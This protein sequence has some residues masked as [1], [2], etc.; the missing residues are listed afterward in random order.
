VEAFHGTTRVIK[1]KL[2]MLY[3]CFLT[4]PNDEVSNC[5]RAIFSTSDIVEGP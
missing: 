4:F 5:I 3:E 1:K 2:D